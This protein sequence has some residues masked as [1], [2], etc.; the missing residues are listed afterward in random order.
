MRRRKGKK[1]VVL[2]IPFAECARVM[3]QNG[4]PCDDVGGRC[5]RVH[6]PYTPFLN[7]DEMAM[8]VCA[9]MCVCVCAYGGAAGG[10]NWPSV[11]QR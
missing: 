7:L 3:M 4:W 9:L 11:E 8:R 6:V 1:C 2:D 5:N 10:S